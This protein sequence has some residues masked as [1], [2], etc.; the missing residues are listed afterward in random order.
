MIFVFSY[1]H[2]FRPHCATGYLELADAVADANHLRRWIIIF[3]LNYFYLN[4]PEEVDDQFQFPSFLTKFA[5]CNMGLGYILPFFF[6]N[7][8][9]KRRLVV[10][11]FYC[12]IGHSISQSLTIHSIIQT[13]IFSSM[14]LFF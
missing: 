12:R 14:T 8:S 6:Y 11:A 1:V 4:F 5:F 13:R 10:H 3:T 7:Y 2:M 9:I